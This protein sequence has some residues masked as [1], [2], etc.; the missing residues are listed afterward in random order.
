M[1]M[2][3]LHG[4]GMHPGPG[5][6]GRGGRGGGMGM[7]PGMMMLQPIAIR[8]CLYVSVCLVCVLGG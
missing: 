2:M 6:M 1:Q 4:I 3:Q 8:V 5:H 7:M